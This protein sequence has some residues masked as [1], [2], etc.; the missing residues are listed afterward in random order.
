MN[1]IKLIA[2]CIF[3]AISLI[4]KISAQTDGVLTFSFT[5]ISHNGFQGTK[6]ALAVWIE[7][8]TG[9]FVKT[10]IRNAGQ[11]GGTSDHLP[12]WAVNS[13]GSSNNCMS[14]A[15][16]I[17]DA[18]TGATLSS[19][20]PKSITWDGKDVI[21]TMNGTL[22][23]DGTYK[24]MI[25]ETWNHGATGK[26]LRSFTFTKG[27]NQD[28]QTPISDANFTNIE[29]NWLP[30]PGSNVGLQELA[31]ENGNS[32]FPN[33]SAG[34]FNVKYKIATKIEVINE[35]GEIILEEKVSNLN[36]GTKAIDLSKFDNGLYFINIY[37]N[38]EYII[39]DVVLKK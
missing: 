32:V 34:V 25:E 22:V 33:P 2:A 23:A 12:T 19:F 3:S 17:T 4:D 9:A 5:P 35:L 14:S 15:C 38:E 18:T 24:V 13:G 1:K 20:T 39:F 26:T 27:P 11:G 36:A 21:G 7:T 6:N 8:G 30:N 10:K 37:N 31:T 28:L 29:L 16:N